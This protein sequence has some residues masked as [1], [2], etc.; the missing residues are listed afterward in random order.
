MRRSAWLVIVTMLPLAL[1]HR[2]GSI[3]A[4]VPL[5][6]N[7]TL[8]LYAYTIV[9]TYPHDPS[10]YTQGLQYVGGI[11]YEG[12]GL[13]GQ[14]SIRKVKLETGEV[15]ERRALGQEHFGEGIALFK[16]TLY[17]LTWKS[18]LAL[19]YDGRTFKPQRTFSYR[20]EG[21][22][23]THDGTN[24]IMSDGTDELRYLDPVTFKERRRLKVR[25]VGKP[26]KELNELEFVK[27]EIFANVWQTDYI[28]RIDPKTGVVTAWIDLR[29]L[30][31][32]RERAIT[33]VLN[34]I[35]YDAAGDRLFVTGKLWP[36]LFHIALRQAR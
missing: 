35:A 10:A 31:S 15:L 23:L 20:G 21:W 5:A 12:T 14:S 24:L 13:N 30:L 9:K 16:G 18:G 26:V 1:A 19:T 3:H 7:A 29:G 25:A 36:K 32:P 28:A 27:G 6:A 8:P 2:S 4:Q 17:Q 22:G 33:D 11:V 34:G